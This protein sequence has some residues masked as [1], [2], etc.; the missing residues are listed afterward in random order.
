VLRLAPILLAV[1]AACLIL[2]SAGAAEQVSPPG[3]LQPLPEVTDRT[4]V[5]LREGVTPAQVAARHELVPRVTYNHAIKG[6]AAA[7]PKSAVERVGRDPGVLMIVPDGIAEPDD[8]QILPTGVDRVDADLNLTAMIDGTDTEL[9]VDIAIIDS[10]IQPD[11]PDL[12]VAGGAAFLGESC[13]GESH[14]DEG[15][16]ARTL[17]A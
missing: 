17:P 10:G 6:F 3:P 5:V 13:S 7:L 15:A 8:E 16:T 14:E 12:R 1:A 2:M 9:D 11:H 4:I